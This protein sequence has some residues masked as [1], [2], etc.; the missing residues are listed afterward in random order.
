MCC[1]TFIVIKSI[2]S[3]TIT[4]LFLYSPL[5]VPCDDDP[6][7]NNE[8]LTFPNYT[9]FL[10]H[11]QYSLVNPYTPSNTSINILSIATI[12]PHRISHVLHHPIPH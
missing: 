3:I 7:I 11:L 2:L 4:P 12:H 9:A 5:P 8:N 6:A 1:F 10:A